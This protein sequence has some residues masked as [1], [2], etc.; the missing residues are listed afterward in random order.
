MTVHQPSAAVDTT[1]EVLLRVHREVLET[2]DIGPDDNFF[3]LGGNSLL[4]FRVIKRTAERL[5][6]RV[7]ARSVFTADSI[8]DLAD[9]VEEARSA[10][11]ASSGGTTATA[12]HQGRASM[13]QEWAVLSSLDDPDAPALQFHVAYRVRGPLDLAALHGALQAL[14]AHHPSLRTVFRVQD[15]T[16]RQHVLPEALPELFVEDVRRLPE[17]ERAGEALRILDIE[18]RRPFDRYAG[19][20]VR[21]HLVRAAP[22]DAYLA[23]V[24]DHMGADG[25]SL[26]VLTADLD[27]AYR[28]RLDGG[29]A[30]LTGSGAYTDWSARQWDR[31]EHGRIDRVAGYWKSQLGDDPSSIAVRL[32]GYRPNQG[33][34]D[35][36]ALHLEVPA[37]VG[38]AL[39]TVCRTLRATPYCV[40]IA[41]LKALVAQQ[42]GRSRVT[43]LT[44]SANRLEP[45]FQ[46]TVG[47]FA[48]GVFPTTDVDLDL[49]FDRFVARV[50]ETALAATAHGD[51]PAWYVRRAMWPQVPS[52]FRKDPGIY[53]MF[54]ELW[55][56]SLRLGGLTVEPVALPETADSPGLHMWLLRDG[57]ALQFTALH[58]R[59]EYTDAYVHEFA[60]T[61]LAAV[62]AL[63]HRPDR[64]MREVLGSGGSLPLQQTGT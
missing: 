13:A 7:S 25:W 22:D 31:F 1:L 54:N 60:R 12:A 30:E 20:L 15:G 14:T 64:P 55:G 39:D 43:L 35:P 58:Y 33:L 28:A 21:A 11:G 51:L 16:V 9:R 23:L 38:E 36:A 2:Q 17:G 19:P 10:D 37:D 3:D 45:E 32:P 62:A 49:P 27:A 44:S 50:T 46:D 57:P 48:N 59:S 6:V 34:S 5:G 24:F 52:G 18:V 29:T 41:A 47:W 53:F 61:F 4:A 63:A 8:R 56:R 42:T 40:T 26:D